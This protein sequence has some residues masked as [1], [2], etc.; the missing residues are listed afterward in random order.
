MGRHKAVR[1]QRGDTVGIISPSW[2]GAGKLPHRVEQGVKQLETL[3]FKVKFGKHALNTLNDFVSDTAENRVSDI[4]ELFQDDNVKAIISAIGGDHSCH[5]LPMLDYDLIAKNPK[6]FMGFSDVTVLNMALWV[7]SKLVTF[8]GPALLTDFAEHPAM[9]TYT[10]EYFL[11]TVTSTEPVGIVEPA[12][13][14]TEEFLDW[15]TQEDLTRA[16][17]LY[18]SPAWTWLKE[19]VAQGVLLGGCIESLQHLRGTPYWCD[20]QNAIFFFETSEE[21]PDP[22]TVEGILTD[23]ENMGVL[24]QLKGLIIGRPAYYSQEEKHYLDEL[25]LE[26]TAKYAFPIITGM[27][28]GHTS[29][30]FTLPVGCSAR[31]NS[32]NKRF[33]ILEAAVR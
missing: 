31:I 32:E 13:E 11:R 20:W 18:P 4:H 1:L 15:E 17:T 19:G 8:N 25:V 12:S 2:G 22:A 29:P 6:V 14:W 21:K 7:K 27:D 30:Q 3:G 5:L 24:E 9:L 33:E 26:R 23:Y 28:F 16:R 10:K